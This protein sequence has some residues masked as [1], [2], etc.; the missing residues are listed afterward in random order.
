[1]ITTNLSILLLGNSDTGKTSLLMKY[2]KNQYKEN[3]VSTVGLDSVVKDLKINEENVRL[4]IMD[5]SGQERF[6]SL[7]QSYYQKVDGI[8]FVFDVTNRESFE[9]IKYWLKDALSY[10]KE[11]VYVIVGNKIDLKNIIV[12]NENDIKSEEIFKDIKYFETSA[13]ENTNVEKPF[14]EIAN[15]ILQKLNEQGNLS[16]YDSIRRAGSFHI[17]NH[18]HNHNNSRKTHS[19][20]CCE[21]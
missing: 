21:K 6:K 5:T 2:A 14:E 20:S 12:V 13:K 17:R 9:G 18:N 10:N 11:I 15:L 1:M 4:Y 19:N 8:I 3:Y 16:V 7:S